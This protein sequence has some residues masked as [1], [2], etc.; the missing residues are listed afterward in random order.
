[1]AD[2]LLAQPVIERL[3]REAGMRH[4]PSRILAA[5]ALCEAPGPVV[6]GVP[7]ANFALIG[8]QALADDDDGTPGWGF[9]YGGLQIRSRYEQR[10]TGK[11][12]DANQLL[13]PDFNVASGVYIKRNE[14]GFSAWTTYTN[15]QYRAY[16][17]EDF[18]PPP[19]TY[20]VW[21]GDTLSSIA[22]KLGGFTW[23]ELARHN[24]LH[25]PYSIHI[26]DVLRLP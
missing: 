17:F 23:Q 1:M 26:G 15:G 24:N 6:D 13:R 19:N 12:R 5:I 2:N 7:H 25:E 11:P 4:R 18:P 20:V 22:A 8:D 16:L 9:S 14:G 21:A 3:A 10:G